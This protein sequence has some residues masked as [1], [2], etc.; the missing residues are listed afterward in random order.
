M[1]IDSHG[2]RLREEI[3]HRKIIPF[4]GVYDVFSASIAARHFDALFMSGFSFA[5]SHFSP[6]PNLKVS[7]RGADEL[8]GVRDCRRGA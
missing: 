7:F 1:M 6:I 2:N 8:E 5:A 3:S 4:I